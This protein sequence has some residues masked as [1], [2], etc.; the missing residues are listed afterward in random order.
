MYSG[1]ESSSKYKQTNFLRKLFTDMTSRKVLRCLNICHLTTRSLMI[2]KKAM[3]HLLSCSEQKNTDPQTRREI[4]LQLDSKSPVKKGARDAA[5][6]GGYR[7]K[8]P[9]LVIVI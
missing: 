8:W 6:T 4:S 2:K 7:P 1:I 3:H 9:Y 5:P